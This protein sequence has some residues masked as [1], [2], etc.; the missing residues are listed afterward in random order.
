M[1]FKKAPG[2]GPFLHKRFQISEEIKVLT[3]FFWMAVSITII[4]KVVFLTFARRSILDR[5]APSTVRTGSLSANKRQEVAKDIPIRFMMIRY[6]TEF[7]YNSL[8]VDADSSE[9]RVLKLSTAKG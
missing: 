2:W 4:G 8:C 5:P 9:K 3:Y 7:R 1:N 6:Y